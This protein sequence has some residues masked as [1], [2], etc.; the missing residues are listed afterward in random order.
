MSVKVLNETRETTIRIYEEIKKT[1]DKK[2][3]KADKEEEID[4]ESYLVLDQL[5]KDD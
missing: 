1:L 5:E 4:F 2:K 3:E